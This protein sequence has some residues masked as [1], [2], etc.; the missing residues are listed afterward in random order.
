MYYR[1]S[2]ADDVSDLRTSIR[3]KSVPGESVSWRL[4]DV[5]LDGQRNLDHSMRGRAVLVV[6][7]L[8]SL[9][10][11]AIQSF[12]CFLRSLPFQSLVFPL[13][14]ITTRRW[15]LVHFS[16]VSETVRSAGSEI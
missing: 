6:V 11:E 8:V 16:S 7:V 14:P 9:P 1:F 5:Q 13:S 4:A 12:S 10:V 3:Q 15:F 2:V